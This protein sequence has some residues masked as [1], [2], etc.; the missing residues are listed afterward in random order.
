MARLDPP[1]VT[2]KIVCDGCKRTE[3]LQHKSGN[4]P[5]G[6]GMISYRVMKARVGTGTRDSPISP[7]AYSSDAGL[8]FCPK[9]YDKIMLYLST[10]MLNDAPSD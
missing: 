4:A 6:W 2:A 7:S 9:C 8:E 3:N 5:E 1:P 10:G